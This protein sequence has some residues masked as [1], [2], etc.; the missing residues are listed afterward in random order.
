[1]T[2]LYVG[3]KTTKKRNEQITRFPGYQ[4]ARGRRF[5]RGPLGQKKI[6]WRFVR[7]EKGE[8]GQAY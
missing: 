5:Q 1:M 3:N 2:K 6:R 8:N 7:Y 4:E